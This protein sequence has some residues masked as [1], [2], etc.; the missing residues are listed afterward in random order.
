MHFLIIG[1]TG[2]N[3]SLA[4]QEALSRGHT[5]TAL[6]RNT[7]TAKL[8]SHSNLTLVQGVPTS[9][10]DITQALTTPQ[11]PQVVITALA[12]VRVTESPFAA[13]RPDTTP[14]FLAVSMKALI[15]AINNSNSPKPKIVVNSSQGAG[16]SWSSMNLPGK[17]IFSHG[18]MGMGLKDHNVVDR[19]VRESGLVFVLS[20]PVM[21][22]E[23]EA[24]PVKVWPDDGKGCAW[25]PKITRESVGKWLVD[26]AESSEWDGKSPVLSN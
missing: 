21:L 10:S 22:A 4:V 17:M 25:M 24:K 12:Q 16:S 6:V 20:R 18:S 8:P 26:A 13:L 11:A 15:A 1:A 19:L 23:G 2:R 7:T 5:V 9:E 14:D 3:G